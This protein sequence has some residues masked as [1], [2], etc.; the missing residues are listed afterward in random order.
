MVS[1]KTERKIVV[2]EATG[3]GFFDVVQSALAF[4]ADT[5]HPIPVSPRHYQAAS[6]ALSPHSHLTDG[7][8]G[9]CQN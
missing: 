4:P 8:L 7:A 3:Y 9:C 5:L 1:A 2:V 6:V